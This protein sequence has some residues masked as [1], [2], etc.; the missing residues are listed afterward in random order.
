MTLRFNR[1]SRADDENHHQRK[2]KGR[3]IFQMVFLM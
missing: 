1:D 2:E 3:K